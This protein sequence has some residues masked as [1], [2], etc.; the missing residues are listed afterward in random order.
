MPRGDHPRNAWQVSIYDWIDERFTAQQRA[1]EML[2]ETTA[3]E[4]KVLKDQVE[5]IANLHAESHQREHALTQEAL[6]KAEASMEK[7]L[8]AMNEFRAQLSDQAATLVRRDYM[9]EKFATVTERYERDLKLM[10]DRLYVLERSASNLS[11]RMWALGGFTSVAVIL[12]NIGIR[13]V[14]NAP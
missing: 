4:T 10:Q 12:I 7:R 3:R 2:A 8:E 1:L 13:L 14:S 9:D 5:H 6:N 11:G